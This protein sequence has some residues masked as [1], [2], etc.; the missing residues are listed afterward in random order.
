ME[1]F[2]VREW[3]ELDKCELNCLDWGW[4]LKDGKMIPIM[5]DQVGF[6]Y[7]YIYTFS[8]K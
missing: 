4:T 5:T 2:Q 6:T 3:V 8:I 7:L 1:L